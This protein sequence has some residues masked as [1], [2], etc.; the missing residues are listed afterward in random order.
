MDLPD[1]AVGLSRGDSTYLDLDIKPVGVNRSI[2]QPINEKTI[3]KDKL[4][5]F[6]AWVDSY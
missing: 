2:S 3:D 5:S 1:L 4:R 6:R